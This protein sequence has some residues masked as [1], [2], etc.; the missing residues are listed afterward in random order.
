MT[1]FSIGYSRIPTSRFIALLRCHHIDVIVNA[2]SQPQS[3]FAPSI[4]AR[5]G[6]QRSNSQ[7]LP[8]TVSATQSAGIR[9]TRSI[10]SLTARSS[11]GA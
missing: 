7:G 10:I 11:I 3:R 1:I 9:R 6:K 2:H 5:P 4:I 8:I